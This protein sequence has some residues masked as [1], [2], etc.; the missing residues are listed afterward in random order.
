MKRI[1]IAAVLIAAGSC[2]FAAESSIRINRQ[3]ADFKRE[4]MLYAFS[5]VNPA[6]QDTDAVVNDQVT[7]ASAA[8]TI[9]FSATDQTDLLEGIAGR[10][11][12]IIVTISGTAANIDGTVDPVL[13][14]VN[15]IGET[16]TETFDATENTEAAIVGTQCYASI[17]SLSIPAQD[18]ANVYVS[19][20]RGSKFGVPTTLLDDG[21]VL[22]S[23]CNGS[24]NEGGTWTVDDDE[25][26]KN[27]FTPTTAPDGS[28]DW[29]M[30]L[31]ISPFASLGTRNLGW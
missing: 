26:E 24:T 17:T 12:N 21:Q 10:A 6:A 28:V 16:V 30:L 14:G 22:W 1:L 5:I 18:G 13:T 25:I 29:K 9:T 31:W 2:S 20:G 3:G 15:L 4:G 7:S 8:T 19:V 11:R 23:E 27:G